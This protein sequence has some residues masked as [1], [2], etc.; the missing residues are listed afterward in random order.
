M[1]LSLRARLFFAQAIAVIVALA[2]VTVLAAHEQ[3][4]WLVERSA[5]ALERSAR[6]AARD[7]P[8]EWSRT[9]GDATE[10][11]RAL[12]SALGLRITLIAKDGRVLG[13]SD[14]P[15]EGLDEVENHRNRAEV[16]EALAGR[17]G[18]AVR[19]SHTLGVEF[20]Y[21]ARPAGVPEIAVLRV[22]EPLVAI[23][24]LRASLLRL[25]LAA[26][27]FALLLTLALAFWIAGRHAARVRELERVAARVGRGEST[28]RAPERPADELGR[29]GRALN[30]MAAEMR[31]R[32]EA[33]V[34]ERDERE[35][36]LAHLRDGVALIDEAGRVLHVNHGLATLLGLALPAAPGTPFA[37]FTR[38]P[39]LD[40]LLR[41]ARGEGRTLESDLRAWTPEARLLHATVTPLGAG[42]RDPLLLVVHDLTENEAVNRMRQDFVANVSH[43]LRTPLT[44]L[45]GYAETLLEGGLDDAEHREG[46]VRVMRDQAVRLEAL[47][48]DVL[49]LAE[50]E[51]PGA[52]LRVERI[53]LRALIERQVAGMKP[54]AQRAGLV[55][56]IEPGAPLIAFADHAR[57]E[58]VI[59]NLLDN[60]LKYTERGGVTVAAGAAGALAWCEVR[61]T[62]PGIP[63]ED[64]PRIF[65]RFYRV[66]KARSRDKGGTGLGLSIVKHIV[67]LH[68]G[69]VSVTSVPG[70]GST[71]RFEIPRGA[72]AMTGAPG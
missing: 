54:R 31:S 38:L 58:Q 21:V 45:R 26:A 71:F 49:A 30:E 64:Q 32:L 47:L 57:L 70:E 3:R 63:P 17:N 33:L 69:S 12:G 68:G 55:L 50:L 62:G 60:A 13:D 52:R 16:A 44:S 35:R 9:G 66:D 7:L 29:L 27:A 65:E 59:A 8:G 4:A 42:G 22:A 61:D 72:E 67:Q 24:G 28:A 46:F 39:E 37:E 25:S 56:A 48:E 34:R 43:E 6:I 11:A 20:L 18:R 41:R 14:V 5:E 10:S 1:N 36:I 51:Q 40:D 23:A 19:R 53:D 2:A 15:R